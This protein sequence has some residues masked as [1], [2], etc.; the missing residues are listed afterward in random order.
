[1]GT[2]VQ[3]SVREMFGLDVVSNICP[4]LV[5]ETS[6]YGTEIVALFYFVNV[7]QKVLWIQIS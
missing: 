7:L 6:T 4:V 2:S 1:M 5:G 3:E